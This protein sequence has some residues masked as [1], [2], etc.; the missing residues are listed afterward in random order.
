MTGVNIILLI[1]ALFAFL[2]LSIFLYKK[3]RVEK[4]L[5]EGKSITAII[6]DI[7]AGYK[8]RYEVVHY[9]F[10]A[11]NGKQYKGKLTTTPGKHRIRETIEVFYLPEN[12]KRNTVKGAWGSTVFLIFMIVITIVVLWMTYKLFQMVSA[13]EI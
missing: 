9:Y 7:V 4:I 12:P 5:K 3:R 2:P 10:T 11:A 13:G 6:F 8:Y 1:L